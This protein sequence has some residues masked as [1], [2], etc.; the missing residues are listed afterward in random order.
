M[1][2][3]AQIKAVCLAAGEQQHGAVIVIR[4]IM[5]VTVIGPELINH[6]AVAVAVIIHVDL[7]HVLALRDM[8]YCALKGRDEQSNSQQRRKC[9][10]DAYQ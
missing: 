2:G 5:A 7:R 6:V 8:G 10:S 3:F 4:N 9:G 1:D